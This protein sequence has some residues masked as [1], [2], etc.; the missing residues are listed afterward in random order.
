MRKRTAVVVL[1][2]LAA[3]LTA[4]GATPKI[5]P[6]VRERAQSE[7]A[8]PVFIVLEHQPQRE[9]FQRAES[10][11]A[12]Y[13]EVA[14]S[15]QAR[16]AAEA[17]VL[18][19]RQQA[20]QAI[21]QAIGPEQDALESRLKGLGATRISRYLGVN[22]LAAEIPA[23]AITALEADPAVARVSAVEKLYP[24]L[25]TSVPALGAPAFW[26]AGYTGQGESVGILDTGIRTGHPAFAG[27]SIVS[28]IFLANGSTDPCF[29]DN[30]GSA[31][32]QFGH[33]THV[34]GI[35]ASQGS[36]GWTN[37]QGVAKGIGTLYNLKVGYTMSTSASCGSQGAGG[38]QRDILA[39]VD[40]AVRNTALKIFNLS[41][42]NV[43]TSDDD[44]FAQAID[45]YIDNYELAFAI[46]AG[47][48]GQAGYGVTS[49][50]IGYNGITVANW[51][52]RYATNSSSSRGP[53]AGGRD[54]PDLAAPGTSIYSAAYNWDAQPG[55]ADDFLMG[56]GTSMAAPHIAGAAALLE[57]A[58]VTD[59]LAVKAVLINTAD[60]YNFEAWV[61][62]G[63]WG[64]TNL[65]T[66][67]AQ[68]NYGSG[69]LTAGSREYYKVSLAGA[70]Q[71]TITWNRHVIG[72]T[73]SFNNVALHLYRG[74]TGEEIASA[75]AG[76][77]NVEQVHA[78]YTGDAV[79]AVE[80]VSAPLA[81][82]SSE[83]Y[84]VA[85]SVP[86]SA[87]ARTEIGVSCSLPSS[88]MSGS[89]FH[90]T[91]S[92]SDTGDFAAPALVGQIALPAG[93][94]GPAQIFFGDL[95]VGAVSQPVTIG[96]TAPALAGTYAIRIEVPIF[97]GAPARAS[98]TLVVQPSLAL[99][100]LI[101]PANGASG[102]S[103]T[104]T[105]SWSAV[106]GA[107]SYDIYLGTMVPPPAVSS[108]TATSYAPGVLYG[109]NVYYWRIVAKNGNGS[110]GSPTW[111]FTTQATAAGQQQY[112]ISTVAG[113]G[114]QGL[115]GDGGPATSAQLNQPSGVT[116]DAAGALYI[117]DR[118]NGRV[119][120]VA[121]DGTI[122]TVAGSG[123]I[124]TFCD[125]RLGLGD[126]G[127][128]TSAQMV[129]QGVAFDAQGNLYIADDAMLIRKV[130]LDGIITT[131]AGNG[132]CGSLSGDG[133]PATSAALGCPNA[134]APYAG[135]GF[136]IA[137]TCNDRIRV[138]TPDGIINSVALGQWF[139]S[140][141]GV[142]TDGAGDVYVAEALYIR[143]VTRDGIVHTI[144]GIAGQGYSGDGGPATAAML[145][146]P[147]GVVVDGSGNLIIADTDNNRVRKVGMD[148]TI[149]TIAGNG[150]ASYSGDGGLA[151][152]ATLNLPGSVA[153]GPGGSVYIADTMNNV[154]R[155]LA[156][157]ANASCQ[158]RVGQTALIAPQSG[159]TLPISIQTGP[160]CWW[161]VVNLPSWVNSQ[162]SGSGPATLNLTVLPNADSLRTATISIAGTA[163]TITQADVVCSYS[164]SAI[165]GGMLPGGGTGSITLEAGANC[166]W[167]ASSSADWLTLTG[168]TSG[169]G[170][171]S[172]SYSVAPNMG[173]VR[174]GTLTIAGL[175]FDLQQD[176]ISGN[177]LHFVPVTPCRVAD[178]RGGAG[179]MAAAETRSF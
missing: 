121:L 124:W 63:G 95:P 176:G 110:S 16:E 66:A 82:V 7:A 105:L 101:S 70:F 164:L 143:E 24:Q 47:N 147:N 129:P 178:T 115:S 45:Q 116:V 18:R 83:P 135:G 25:A 108:T 44:D 77:Q 64:Y 19:T 151:T 157:L 127:P 160:G 52:A 50:G 84:G 22:M 49:P 2:G 26:N 133:G 175:P 75:P 58:G 140:P 171:G 128:A 57:S 170:G 12:L 42:G 59:P 9:I 144:A 125:G 69:S 37:Y 11:N 73:S 166:P 117:A 136:Y 13:R 146:Q 92:V 107:T 8:V 99:P 80:M 123:G 122:T 138:V 102:V 155:V 97:F 81:G 51:I 20:F 104:P 114:T 62:D 39:A 119:R 53:T 172:V 120:K 85:F 139:E 163:V 165:D 56:T 33:G 32:D 90:M 54:K 43:T 48:G 46:A 126:G 31:E 173:G 5:H 174:P 14:E 130:D 17:V 78:T 71:A 149:A 109:S 76:I 100:V 162:M 169:V 4:T 153:T 38:D 118:Q 34:A 41:F 158:Y 23:S 103:F 148:G 1:L 141:M 179:A 10:A 86:G 67:L 27:V 161:S 88:I 145:N 154:V 150:T 91:C 132:G 15:R 142:A 28:Q 167:T 79:L 112:T 55:T 168:S 3:G 36:A 21:E 87:M 35:V 96:L 106:A 131:V 152:N 159:G 89:A 111:S 98:Y 40:W 29:T 68:L 113:N 30:A 93:F 6:R 156:P 134:V 177:G 137:D 94:S 72:S 61:N 65:N 74:D 60:G